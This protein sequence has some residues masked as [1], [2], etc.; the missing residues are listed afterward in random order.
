MMEVAVGQSTNPYPKGF[1]IRT[2][3]LGSLRD[4]IEGGPALSKSSIDSEHSC[5]LI[6]I[7]SISQKSGAKGYFLFGGGPEGGPA[8][9]PSPPS[10]SLRLR[11]RLRLSHC[12]L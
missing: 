9:H 7:I 2:I 8:F 4:V 3:Q 1:S 11:L 12:R 10:G 5:L 6:I